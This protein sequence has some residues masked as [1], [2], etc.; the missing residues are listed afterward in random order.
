VKPEQQ[1][2]ATF[3]PESV[4]STQ[5]VIARH[6]GVSSGE[7]VPPKRSIVSRS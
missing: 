2:G 1:S 7:R 6:S 4:S 3:A 5:S